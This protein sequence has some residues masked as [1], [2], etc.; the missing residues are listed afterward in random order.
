MPDKTVLVT[1]ATGY[2]GGRLVPRLL[3]SGYRVRAAARS[4]DKLKGRPWSN[5][6]QLELMSFDALDIN[7]F[8]QVAEDCWAAYYLIHSMNP[9]QPNFVAA[10]RQAAT[11]MI[12]AAN[13][14]KLQRIIYLGGL[15]EQKDNLSRHLRSRAEVADILQTGSVPVTVL[16]AAMIIGSG[17]ASFEILRYLVDRL[18]I[19]I[20]PRWVTTPSQPIAIRDVLFYLTACLSNE[21]TTGKTFDIGGPDILTYRQLME[22]YAEEAGLPTR[23]IIPVPVFTPKLSSYW[24]H[25]VTPVPAHI[26][27]PLADGLRNPA[28]CLDTSIKELLPRQLLTCREAI[29]LA[30]RRLK[31]NQIESHWIDAGPLP[32]DESAQELDP[33]WSGG[34]IYRE[35]RC[36]IVDTSAAAVWQAVSRIGGQAGW[37]YAN[38]LWRLRGLLD[39]LVGGVGLRRGRRHAQELLPGDALDFWRVTKVNPPEYLL[40]QAEM[41]LPGRALLEFRV[42]AIDKTQTEITQTACFIPKGLFGILYWK[43]MLPF[44]M[45]IFDGMLRGLAEFASRSEER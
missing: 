8:C 7:S 13:H 25:L 1:G 42:R 2:V 21:A 34:T 22:I 10:D 12:A 27:R 11:N 36:R 23:I 26:A 24:I 18:P 15:G 14:S 4:I 9:Q 20:T 38:W 30:L 19:M 43:S 29:A 45:F 28:L 35:R 33:K 31:D 32:E 41:K 16:R 44:H 3:E 6:P 37:Y 40:L 5:H 17:S 39:R